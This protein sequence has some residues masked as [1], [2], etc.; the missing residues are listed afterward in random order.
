MSYRG[1]SSLFLTA[2]LVLSACS[3]GSGSSG[4]ESP[5][6]TQEPPQYT[7]AVTVTGSGEVSPTQQRIPE[8]ERASIELLP[9]PGFRV[10]NASGCGGSLEGTQYTTGVLTADCSV[11]VEFIPKGGVS[12][13]LLPA[14]GTSVD[15]TINDV[16]AD[17][18][19]NSSCEQAQPIDNRATL[20]GFASASGT[21]GD[22]AQE[23]FADSGNPKDFYRVS[24]G[25]GQVV[26]LDVADYQEGEHELELYLRNADCSRLIASSTDGG[27][28]HRVSAPLGGER[29]IEVR[30][31]AGVSK[32]VLRVTTVWDS[33]HYNDEDLETYSATV[34]EFVPGEVIITFA[35]DAGNQPHDALSTAL[36]RAKGRQL[37]FRHYDTDRATLA[38]VENTVDRANLTVRLSSVLDNLKERNEL[39]Y[40]VIQNLQIIDFL[41]Q[42]PGVQFAEPNYVLR[43]QTTPND[44]H[45]GHQWHYNQID[46]PDA[47]QV[48]LGAREDGE[49]VIVAV[50]D[51]GVYLNHEDLRDKMLPGYDFHDGNDDPDEKNGNSNWHGTHVAGTVGA[52][53]NN[54]IGVAGVS[55]QAKIMPVRVLG[56]EGGS[57]Y[58][59][60][61]GVRYAA[62][63]SND[64][65]TVPER[66]ADVINMSLGGGGHSGSEQNL[67][68][69]VRSEGTLLVAAAG[70]EDTDQPMYPAAYDGVLSV[71]AT[72]CRD[73]RA[74]YSNYG[75]T[76]SLAAPGGGT[77]CLGNSNGGILSTVGDD[78]GESLESAYAWLQGTSMA[79]PHVAGVLALMRAVYPDLTPNQVDALLESGELT[80][81][82][83]D[84]SLGFGL[85]NAAKAVQAAEDL[86][87]GGE[88]AARVIADPATL[89][90]GQDSEAELEL[91]Q[92]GEGQAPTLTQL[93]SEDG[94]LSASEEEVD[95]NGLGR[96]RVQVDR[97]AFE[98]ED[99]GYHS[100]ELVFSFSN[101]TEI[102]VGVHIQ[103]GY[104]SEAAPI[105]VLLL[106]ADTQEP[107]RQ[108]LASW[109]SAGELRYEL[110]GVEP[111]DYLLIAGS[112]IDADKQ[113]CQ[114]G[115]MC[116]AYPSFEVRERI[117]ITDA[118][119]EDLDIP[120]DIL[121][122]FRPFDVEPVMRLH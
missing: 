75:P 110:E 120:L 6:D 92:E 5:N 29:V 84:D 14:F 16:Q 20:H 86:R 61:Q 78:S 49:D 113:I 119:M 63:L 102:R 114:P 39:A 107:V 31:S 89:Y 32:Y 53:T 36:N 99:H 50:L 52:S 4:P 66:R 96:Y 26:Q 24:L 54:S 111:G 3:G 64:S 69:Q 1:S 106:D 57:R 105:Y 82:L 79:S 98:E 30:A 68:H 94:W 65:G 80:D 72:D 21:E 115:E 90:L 104:A 122:R 27:E 42:Q 76:I 71:A 10:S 51:T 43:H 8:G 87:E 58:N 23:H 91:R 18:G 74:G 13:V 100:S 101:D 118:M 48:T 37:S 85:I 116:G 33:G 22:P 34:P 117:T 60:I 46:L 15:E 41:S 56:D 2:F 12:G 70:N 83:D 40:E 81:E 73:R 35:P 59:V 108:V 11:T 88:T 121:T 9:E 109:T 7:V 95:E 28:M 17:L 19:E 77:N 44:T 97:S 103:V 112:D 25:V 62:G 55:W 45:Y 47:W 93:Q 38:R 67:Y